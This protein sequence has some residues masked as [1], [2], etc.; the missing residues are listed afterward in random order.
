MLLPSSAEFSL[1]QQSQEQFAYVLRTIILIYLMVVL[2]L[3]GLWN[4]FVTGASLTQIVLLV[5]I[6]PVVLYLS[7]RKK[8][9]ATAKQRQSD[10]DLSTAIFLDLLNVLLAGG[11]GVETAILA[12]AACG[13]GWG[14]AQIRL[15]IARSQ[16]SRQSYWDGLRELGA[17]L[18]NESLIEVANSVQLAGEH[19]ARI[20]QSLHSKAASLRQKNLARIEYEAEQRTE[21]MGLPIVLLFLGFLLLIGYPAFM[22]TIGAL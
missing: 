3:L 19:G 18:G 5:L 20:R 2:T 22:G 9:Q 15:S 10:L 11:A 4:A 6:G 14:F 8:I 16:S 12:A 17:S 7:Q 21:K 13:D 1:A